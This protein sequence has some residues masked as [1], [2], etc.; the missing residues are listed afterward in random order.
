MQKEVLLHAEGICKS[1]GVTKAL[2]NVRLELHRGEILG[3]MGENGSGKSTLASIIAAIQQADHGSIEYKG[4]TYHPQNCVEAN[5]AGVCMII[6]EKGTFDQL[7]VA[8]NIFAGK[9]HLFRKGGLIDRKKMNLEAER[10]LKRIHAD[11]P[12]NVLV[13]KLSFE[14]RKLVELAR[15]VWNDPEVLIIDETTTA[16]SREGRDILYTIMD[17]MRARDKG[18]IFISHDID[19]LMQK[20][21]SLTVLRDGVFVQTLSRGEFDAA[22]IRKLMVGR[23]ITDNYYRADVNS[24]C[25]EKIVL[26][27]QNVQTAVLKNI[28]FELHEGE[29]LGFGGLAD[30][31]MHDIGRV[32]F[33]VQQ[34]DVGSVVIDGVKRI[35]TPREAMNEGVAYI[36]K[37]RDQESLMSTSSIRDNISI[38]SYPKISLGPLISSK[39]E[40]R[41]V[42]QWCEAME[43]KMRDSKQYVMEL[44][45]GNKQKV[46]LAKWLGFG[47]RI[48]ILDCP[49]RGIDIGVK[50]NIYQLM[51]QLKAEGKSIILISEELPELIGMIDRL[52]I[53]KEGRINGEFKREEGLTETK[54]I[55][56]MV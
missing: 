39:R 36:A 33:G 3:L 56:Y 42:N 40:R 55:D 2:N 21:D 28:S 12:A 22:L 48:L 51:M 50:S 1:F 23:D 53:L 14:D 41:F 11:I 49:T 52:I 32:L 45:G 19:E 34:P 17:D 8:N 13:G 15:S 38:V 7:T 25:G 46:A 6:Q 27:A 44:S 10:I 29:I 20:C 43:V 4:A 9:E 37:N 26:Q 47:A 54:L 24:T 31:G 35:C 5:E 18:I 16:L 30:S